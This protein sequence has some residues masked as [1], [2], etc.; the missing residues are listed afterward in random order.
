MKSTETIRDKEEK[1]KLKKKLLAKKKRLL[2][3]KSELLITKNE[4]LVAVRE[5]EEKNKLLYLGHPGKGYLGE[6][7]TWSPNKPQ[8]ALIRAIEHTDCR[9]FAA[10]GGN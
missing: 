8:A 3:K 5:Y 7:G 6:H 1:E 2:Q 4:K 10:V 9:I